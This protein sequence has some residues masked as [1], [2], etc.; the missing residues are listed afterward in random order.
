MK[1]NFISGGAAV[2]FGA[3]IALGPQYLFKIC[4]VHEAG[5]AFCYWV[6]RAE[7]SMGILIAVLGICMFIFSDVKVQ[8]GL[9]IGIFLTG[10]VALLIPQDMFFGVCKDAEMSCNKYTLPSLTVI[11][12]VLIIGAIV[13]MMS[14]E[15]KSR[16]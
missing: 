5:A 2:L 14:L 11:C 10:I 13:N 12:A 15:K 9:S 1:R 3:L 6:G 4:T 8:L 16:S 7:I